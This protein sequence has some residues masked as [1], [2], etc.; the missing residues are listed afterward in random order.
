M[1]NKKIRWGVISCARIA[2]S[3]VIPGIKTSPHSILYAIAG[4]DPQRLADFN[5][6]HE[7]EKA[8]STYE[9]LLDDP[10]VDAVYIPLPNSLHFEWVLKASQK[11]KHILCE[12]PLGLTA[13]E[14]SDMDAACKKNG[15]LLMEAFDYRHNPAVIKVKELVDSGVA[16]NIS[17]IE[18]YFSINLTNRSDIRMIKHLGGGAVYDIG[19]YTVNLI[20]YLKGKLPATIQATAVFDPETGVDMNTCAMYTYDDDTLAVFHCSMNSTYMN[21]FR[22][23]GDKAI[24][25]YPSLYHALGVTEIRIH[26]ENATEIIKIDC[27]H[28]Y[29]L[30]VEQFARCILFGEKPLISIQETYDNMLTV[31][32]IFTK[33]GYSF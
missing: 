21:G 33:I 20:N 12:K 32:R 22:I 6:R 17:L 31:E 27:P 9:E 8:Y 25:E 10:N 5:S 3:A 1:N 16:G 4:K 28:S 11:G 29:M 2:D 24:I 7:P 23:A 19:T 30:E 26:K 15:V 14:V 18:G 13:K